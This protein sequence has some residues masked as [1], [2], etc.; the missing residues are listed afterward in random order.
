MFRNYLRIAWRNLIRHKVFSIV[1]IIGLAIGI[2]ICFIIF[3]FVSDELSFDR[4]N[5][6][7]DDIVRVVF[8]ADINGGKIFEA[9]V[10]PQVA[11]AM[12]NDYPEVADA[13]RL[14]QS[15]FPKI[16]YGE[17]KLKDEEMAYVDPNFFSIFTLP[18]IEGDAA[19]A[20]LE[21]G[22]MVITRSIADKIFGK[23]EAI[24]KTLTLPD[25]QNA[26]FRITGVINDIPANAHFHF[27]LYASMT[28]L[29]DARSN[30]WMGSNFFTYV[31]LQKGT[32][33]HALQAKLPGM[34]TKYIGP[35]IQQAMGIS[36]EQFRTKGNELGFELQPLTSIHLYSHSNNELSP[37]GDPKYV[38][39]FSAI[40]I[41]MLLIACINFI[42]LS[43]AGASKRAKEVGIRKVIGS[44]RGALVRQFLLESAVLVGIS[45][46]VAVLFV[47]L[48][49]PVFNDLSGKHLQLGFSWRIILSFLALGVLVSVLAGIYPAFV[50]SSFKPVIVLKG[51]AGRTGKKGFSLRSG[52][53]VFQFIISTGLIIGTLVVWQQ[54]KYIQ[55]INLGYQKEQ[56]LILSNSY[57]LGKQEPVFKEEMLKDPR[58][59]NATISSYR[60][61][62]PSNN[63]N[64]LAYAE[65][66]ED[67]IMKTIEFHIDDQYI[68]T[69]SM[70]M[71]AGRNFS[72]DMP[73][74]ST[75]MIINEKAASAFGWDDRTAIGK[76]IIRQ[77]S[78]RGFNVPYHIVGVVRDF[79]FKSLH[80]PITPLLMTLESDYGLICKVK[81]DNITGLI[82]DMKHKWDQFHTGEPFI[83]EF[84][85]DLYNK[86]YAAEEKT[87]TIL[88][89]FAVL[90]IF[91]ACLGLFGL[92]TYTAE[93]RIKEI[94][95]RKVLG[96]SVA[97][98]TQMLSSAF[99]KLVLVACC[100]AFPIAWWAMDKWLQGFAY[101][102]HIGWW[103][104]ALSGF[105]TILIAVCTI[106]FQAIR[107]A[108]ANPIKALRTE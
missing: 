87:G 47:K 34:V 80:E 90:T 13:T 106:S 21:P 91:V 32:D 36:L 62:G 97:Q 8:K 37:P 99:I 73:T 102:I 38:Y 107:S 24:G 29:P 58:I 66:H 85:D 20:L 89:I 81:T 72:K 70:Q 3:L 88:N 40:A 45:L 83:Y 103:M 96:A 46:V 27:N 67:Q 23:E 41:F 48:T 61:A 64:A 104:Y 68:P 14:F 74:D 69:F 105:L 94:G 71:A 57:A 42:N 51:A 49:L 7:A 25:E 5:K 52:L 1:N 44:G 11:A 95:I 10:M 54:M 17:K 30:S 6:N 108:M 60:P 28:G 35:Q 4:F 79:N 31:L 63:N 2:T 86:T 75:A 22:S 56:L 26:R 76:T 93:Q 50:L 92:A 43:T 101:R 9:N 16:V 19:K 100:I 15:G 59:V 98:I 53:V 39:I 82:S 55:H 18:F 33:Y 65:G 84:M 12:K 78:D 77:N